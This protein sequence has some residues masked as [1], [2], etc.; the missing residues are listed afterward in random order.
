MFTGTTTVSLALVPSVM[1]VVS[2]ELEGYLKEINTPFFEQA[3]VAHKID[4]RIGDALTSLD[5]LAR[6][7]AT[8]DMVRL[9]NRLSSPL[10]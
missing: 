3:H 10:L 7:G 8:F 4:V 6:E 1:K 5:T 2:L 9:S